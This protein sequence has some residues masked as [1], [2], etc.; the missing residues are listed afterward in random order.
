[1]HAVFVLDGQEIIAMDSHEKHEFD[2]SEGTSF[3][4][5]TDGQEET[6]YFR[7]NLVADG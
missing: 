2:F 3:V 1:M 7:N 4:I 5:N 6:D